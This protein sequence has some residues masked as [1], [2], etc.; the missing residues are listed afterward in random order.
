MD[1]RDIVGDTGSGRDTVATVFGNRVC[2]IV[3]FVLVG[4]AVVLFIILGLLT[5]AHLSGEALLFSGLTIVI[6]YNLLAPMPQILSTVGT[7]ERRSIL[8]YVTL[9]RRTMLLTPL[10]LFLLLRA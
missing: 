7:D 1:A 3:A 8:A 6:A 5:I 10:W 4:S 2:K 9:S